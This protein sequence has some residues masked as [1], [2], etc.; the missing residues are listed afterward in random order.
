[1]APAP[2]A[3]DRRLAPRFEAVV[4]CTLS[5]ARGSAIVARTVDVGP[6]GMC[7]ST[8]RPLSADEV[9]SFDLQPA[10]DVHVLGRARVLRQE[11]RDTY[12]L[13]FEGLADAVREQLRALVGGEG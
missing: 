13:R 6:G 2:F 12:A 8:A 1:M 3:S 11:G 9:L 5:R 4:P 10:G 7:L